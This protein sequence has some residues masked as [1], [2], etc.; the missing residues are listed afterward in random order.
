[1]T[2]GVVLDIG[3]EKVTCA[4]VYRGKQCP[5]SLSCDSP[6]A[7]PGHLASLV[8]RCVFEC[9]ENAEMKSSLKKN[10]V[11]CSEFII[12]HLCRL[13]CCEFFL[14]R[15]K[16]SP[17]NEKSIIKDIRNNLIK[18]DKTYIVI[19]HGKAILL[20]CTFITTLIIR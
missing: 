19:A 8:E 7:T 6:S 15:V 3:R 14:N 4:A 16:N 18:R 17:A 2:C 20:L 1:M 5:K 9:G 13:I 11:I 10:A 12:Y